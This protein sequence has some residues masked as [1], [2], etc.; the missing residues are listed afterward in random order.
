MK[1]TEKQAE[2]QCQLLY[3]TETKLATE[4]QATLD[5]KTV[6]QKSKEEVLLA[7]EVAEDKKRAAYQIGVK[8]TEARLAEE[9][10]EVCRDYCSITWGQALNATSVPT[11]STWRLPENIFYPPKIREVLADA[12][13]ASE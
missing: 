1:N 7:K 9:L 3:V 10:S 4:K 8:E 12:P 6:L 5:L 2:D 11:D 13:E